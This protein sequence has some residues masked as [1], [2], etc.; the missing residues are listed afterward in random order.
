MPL[1]SVYPDGRQALGSFSDTNAAHLSSSVY[2]APFSAKAEVRDFASQKNSLVASDAN[3]GKS[4]PP[5]FESA[6]KFLP[7]VELVDT[8]ASEP[9]PSGISAVITD[10]LTGAVDEIKNDPLKVVGEAIFGV[11]IVAGMTLLAPEV[12]VALGVVGAAA[13]VRELCRN[14]GGW[15]TAASMVASPD[16]QSP[17]DLKRAHAELRSFGAGALDMAVGSLGAAA[18]IGIK[19]GVKALTSELIPSA[20]GLSE[21]AHPPTGG[22]PSKM[23]VAAVKV[24]GDSAGSLVNITPQVEGLSRGLPVFNKGASETFVTESLAG[25]KN[26]PSAHLELIKKNQVKIV[27]GRTMAEINPGSMNDAAYNYKINTIFVSSQRIQTVNL[28]SE[29]LAHE[30]GH[31]LDHALGWLSESAEFKSLHELTIMKGA[32]KKPSLDPYLISGGKTKTITDLG[33]KEAFA[34]FY[35][36][37]NESNVH[38]DARR[39]NSWEALSKFFLDKGLVN[40][41][42]IPKKVVK[43]LSRNLKEALAKYPDS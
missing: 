12:A 11:G 33:R 6:S 2:E 38:F 24:G 37:W 27:F 15:L 25:L 17:A 20:K 35:Q 41:G 36:A 40:K 10:V 3:A 13:A 14:T 23:T 18:G 1:E 21:L 34:T 42:A 32:A 31:A 8:K 4:P 22:P 7:S 28:P 30:A 39:H 16:Q 43:G 26:L 9:V 19:S 29:V 5:H